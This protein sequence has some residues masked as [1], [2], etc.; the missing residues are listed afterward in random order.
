M[1]QPIDTYHALYFEDVASAVDYCQLLVGH[2]VPRAKAADVDEYRPIVWFHVPRRCTTSTRDGCYLFASPAAY[3]AATRA[4]LDT[5]MSGYITADAVPRE[6]VLV[7]GDV[8]PERTSRR[9]LESRITRRW[10]APAAALVETAQPLRV[11][12]QA[13]TR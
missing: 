8:V 2:I 9:P 5:P 10:V 12:A 13:T 7:F 11:T 4:G 1:P 3:F 6:S